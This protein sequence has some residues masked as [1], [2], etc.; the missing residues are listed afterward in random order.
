[1]A[2]PHAIMPWELDPSAEIPGD[3]GLA[4]MP[5][6]RKRVASSMKQDAL[7][8]ERPPTALLPLLNSRGYLQ[9]VLSRL[10]GVNPQ[11][12][13]LKVRAAVAGVHQASAGGWWRSVL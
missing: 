9:G 11:D 3:T 1:M 10:P 12:A 13:S 8:G 6:Q 2:G 5:S 7:G 4:D